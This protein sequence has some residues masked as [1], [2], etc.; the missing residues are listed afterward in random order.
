MAE[1]DVVVDARLVPAIMLLQL[2][3]ATGRWGSVTIR[4]QDGVP[5]LVE[6][7]ETVKFDSRTQVMSGSM[8]VLVPRLPKN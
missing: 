6:T 2:Y 4:F 8:V 5:G 7:N 1:K 3:V